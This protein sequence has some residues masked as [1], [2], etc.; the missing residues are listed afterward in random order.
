MR[1]DQPDPQ[2]IQSPR[3]NHHPHF[4][5]L[6]DLH[7]RQKIQQRKRLR[8][9]PQIS[10]RQ[11]GNNKWMNNNLS[12]I[13]K[14]AHLPVAPTEM[15]HPNRRIGENQRRAARRRGTFFSSGIVP[16]SDASLRAL[17]LSIRAFSAS[18]TSAVFSAT[19]VN[20]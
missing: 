15:I 16:P 19:P 20:S 3:L 13:E 10:Q 6:R 7:L 2:P 1:I 9:P 17:S 12:L 11:L 8:P 14:L 4:G 18:R 5:N